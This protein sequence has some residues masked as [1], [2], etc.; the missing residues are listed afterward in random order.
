M[1]HTD[2]APARRLFPQGRV[3]TIPAENSRN[4][5]LLWLILATAVTL[6]LMALPLASVVTFPIRMFVTFIHEGSHALA[7]LL[8]G[9][10]VIRMTV[11][12]DGS[13]LTLTAGQNWFIA[14]AGYL[15]TMLFGVWLLYQAQRRDRAGLLLVGSGMLVLLLTILFVN[16]QVSWLMVLPLALAGTLLLGG[17]RMKLPMPV[18]WGMLGAGGLLLFLLA[19][20]C[21]LTGTLYSWIVGLSVGVSLVVLGVLTK[22]AVGQFIVN[23]LA[24]QCCL[25]ALS[26]LKTLF[27]LSAL[28][29]VQSDAANMA[30]LTGIPAM[31]WATLWLFSGVLLLGATLWLIFRRPTGQYGAT[32]TAR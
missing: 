29:N 32:A 12:W 22:P 18:R 17:L 14:S 26:D 24:V 3:I 2:D 10:H 15:G 27:F 31:V 11:H 28:T 25:D 9:Y 16:G 8:S 30:R 19:V 20:L 4:S 6:M 5:S 13:G 1:R 7:A 21:V 23:F